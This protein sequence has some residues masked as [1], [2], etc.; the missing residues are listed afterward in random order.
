MTTSL[1]LNLKHVFPNKAM[2]LSNLLS[3]GL[4]ALAAS[5]ASAAASPKLPTVEIAAG[6]FMPYLSC[7]HPDDNSTELQDAALWFEAGG[8][9]I[10]TAYD[11]GNQDQVG[12]AV[13]DFLEQQHGTGTGKVNRS[14]LFITTKISPGGH[15][16]GKPDN[17]NKCTKAG[18][19]AAVREDLKELQ[20]SYVDLALH[21]FPCSTTAETRAV[22]QGLQ[23]AQKLG[24]AR[25]IGVSNFGAS[26]LDAVLS[27]GGVPPAV[28]QCQ[29]SIGSRDEATITYCAAKGIVYQAYSALRH[30]NLTDAR[31][32]AKN[33]QASAAQVGST[34][35]RLGL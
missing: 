22:W 32:V 2:P 10:D 12:K 25:A 14:S 24:L 3:L 26:D 9:G 8:T 6:V 31:I 21:H 20:L 13:R 35:S 28:N 19:L 33:H 15:P 30:V 23:A 34:A 16:W 27:L 5:A 17:K 29:M 4:F 1:N 18:A 7:G 11:Y